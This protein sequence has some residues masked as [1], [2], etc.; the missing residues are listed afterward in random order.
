MLNQPLTLEEFRKLF[1]EIDSDSYPD[2]AVKARL[3]LAAKFFSE[4]TWPDPVIRAH[5]MGL[6]TAHYLTFAKSA[7]GGGNGGDNSGLGQVSSMSVDGASVSYDTSSSSEEGAGSWN[8][9]AYGREVW[10]LIQLFGAGA[11]QI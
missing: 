6:Y 4:E 8:L 1:P 11:R 9:T 2:V 7:A 10:Q 5:V 3:A